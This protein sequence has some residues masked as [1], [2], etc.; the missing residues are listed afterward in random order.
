MTK[1]ITSLIFCLLF[2]A[3]TLEAQQ[4][5]TGRITDRY[6]G[7]PIPGAT[8]FIA[9]TTVGTLS[10]RYGNFSIT[11]PIQ[12]NFIVV[13]SHIGFQSASRTI[14]TPQP[15]HQVNFTLQENILDE[16]VVTP[17]IPHERREEELFWRLFLGESPSNRGMQVLNPEVVRFCLLPIGILRVFA[18]EPIEIIN[19]NMGYHISYILYYFEH[20]FRTLDFFIAG[21]P[22]F[23]ELTPQ[24]R[25]QERSWERERLLRLRVLF[26]LCIKNNST[27]AV[28][29]LQ[30]T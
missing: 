24:N 25:R 19:H 13:V 5:V 12:G 3:S 17:C 2:V 11:A 4:V 14:D 23:T 18:D 28:S 16:V 26:E 6:D 10:D 27:K 20:D 29:F 22:F 15:F 1:T 30:K 9:H 8:V 21:E 7:T